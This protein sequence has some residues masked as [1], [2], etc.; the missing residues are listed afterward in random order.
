MAK[1]L[2]AL[3]RRTIYRH[4]GNL[5]SFDDPFA[6]MRRLLRGVEVRAIVDVGASDGRV[7]RVLLK[8]FPAAAVYAFEPQPR[9]AE[10]LAGFAGREPRFRPQTLALVDAPRTVELHVTQSPGQSS[11]LSPNAALHAYD[12]AG[13]TVTQVVRVPGVRLDDWAR[14]H[15]VQ[16]QAM[17]LDIQQAELVALR[18]ADRLLRESLRAVYTEVFFNPMYDGGCLFGDIDRCLRDRG[19]SLHDLYRPRYDR[20]GRVAWAN[21]L[22]VRP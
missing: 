9:Y 11:L 7:S 8:H 22:Y 15:A 14:E 12:A 17:K 16:P 19:F 5:V 10:A 13:S 1:T 3:A 20:Q 21:A 2:Q 6:T 4:S 18:G